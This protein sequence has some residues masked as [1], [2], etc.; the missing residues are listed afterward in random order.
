VIVGSIAL[1]SYL[2]ISLIAIIS[3][4]VLVA[5][6]SV[7][8][9]LRRYTLPAI[10]LFL[11]SSLLAPGQYLFDSLVLLAVVLVA[12]RAG[13]IWAL[14]R[15]QAVTARAKRIP[16]GTFHRTAGFLATLMVMT[17]FLATISQPWL[18]AEIVTLKAPIDSNLTAADPSTVMTKYP[19][20]FVL[21]DDNGKVGLLLDSDRDVV[22][23]DASNIVSQRICNLNNELFG[24]GPFFKWLQR[25]AFQ[26]H[27][28]S[29]W[30]C[31]DQVIERYKRNAPRFIRLL[32]GYWDPLYSGKIKHPHKICQ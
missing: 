13:A 18:P 6:Y 17:F 7:D 9:A 19:V 29:C 20:V 26:P 3:L 10:A 4:Y 28:I 11:F 14:R 31:T 16:P 25:E 15:K 32:E 24:K 27:I 1:Y 8:P 2:F 22:Y 21:G 30:H 12:A 23:T 5:A